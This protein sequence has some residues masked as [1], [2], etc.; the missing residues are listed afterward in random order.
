M[1]AVDIF[2]VVFCFAFAAGALVLLIV[3][4]KAH[5]GFS[6]WVRERNKQNQRSAF[7]PE[8]HLAQINAENKIRQLSDCMRLLMTTADPDV[9]FN[10]YAFAFKI[11]TEL[12]EAHKAGKITLIEDISGELEKA[13]SRRHEDVNAFINRAY[14]KMLEN[15]EFLKTESGKHNRAV[16]FFETMD[17]HRDKMVSQNLSLLESLKIECG[18]SPD[19]EASLDDIEDEKNHIY[20][21]IHKL[22]AEM[23]IATTKT[24]RDALQKKALELQGKLLQ[25]EDEEWELL[26]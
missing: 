21:E 25:L 3:G 26:N 2:I 1:D 11:M 24:K 18:L 14:Q 10:R 23:E 19:S 20:N 13:Y 12:S 6:S 22:G 9:F 16:K 17:S 8:K 4:S 7:N 5:G 15:R